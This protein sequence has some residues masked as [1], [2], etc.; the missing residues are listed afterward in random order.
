MRKRNSST[1]SR[2]LISGVLFAYDL[3]ASSPPPTCCVLNR[4]SASL[5][6]RP[7]CSSFPHLP[8]LQGSRMRTA[9]APRDGASERTALLVAPHPAYKPSSGAA[10]RPMIASGTAIGH[11]S[12]SFPPPASAASP[13]SSPQDPASHLAA[14]STAKSDLRRR[15]VQGLE[16]P[17]RQRNATRRFRLPQIAFELENKGSVARDHLAGE[18]TFLAWLRTSLAL[19]SIGIGE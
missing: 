19:A 11:P 6:A 8:V 4:F 18:R 5:S 2:R 3:A 15:L 14:S 10:Q 9:R 16:Q 7:C 1:P 13:S 17:A 12:A